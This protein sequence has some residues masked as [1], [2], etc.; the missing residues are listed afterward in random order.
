MWE[1]QQQEAREARSGEN[2]GNAEAV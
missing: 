2:A 1:L